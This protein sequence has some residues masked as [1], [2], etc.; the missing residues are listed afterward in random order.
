MSDIEKNELRNKLLVHMLLGYEA[1]N[2]HSF[3]P[4][5]CNSTYQSS[6]FSFLL[7]LEAKLKIAENDSIREGDISLC[8]MHTKPDTMCYICIISTYKL[9]RK[10][11]NSN[12]THS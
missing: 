1:N 3:W 8:I 6:A 4:I 2:M 12:T 9:L 7:S 11:N 10:M 5:C